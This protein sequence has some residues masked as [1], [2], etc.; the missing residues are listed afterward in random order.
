[1]Q[2]AP[3]GAPQPNK[4]KGRTATVQPLQNFHHVSKIVDSA[5]ALRLQ[6]LSAIG[7][8]GSRANLIATLVWEVSHG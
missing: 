7:I 8:I 1:M 5:A 4:R 6:R 3:A 2:A